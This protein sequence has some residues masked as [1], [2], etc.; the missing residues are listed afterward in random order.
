M[1]DEGDT[2]AQCVRDVFRCLAAVLP[3]LLI[4][5]L[6][7]IVFSFPNQLLDIYRDIAQSTVLGPVDPEKAGWLGYLATWRELISAC[8][9]VTMLSI[10]L[11]LASQVLVR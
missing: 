4:S 5:V 3:A 1:A 6:A 10:A 11:W 8:V 7:S 2:V 9:A